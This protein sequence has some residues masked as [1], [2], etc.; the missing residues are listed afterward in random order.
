MKWI[1]IVVLMF[2]TVGHAGK[3]EAGVYQNGTELL[4]FCESGTL[5][6]VGDN[7]M[8]VGYLAGLAD[9][10]DF[11]GEYGRITEDFCIPEGVTLG[12]LKKVAIKG[13]N[14]MPQDLHLAASSLVGFIFVEAFPC[15]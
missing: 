5:G 4:A 9:I 12:Q 14:E 1:A 13:L 2:A 11:Y 3:A 7:A 15:Y 8:C 10:T 6:D